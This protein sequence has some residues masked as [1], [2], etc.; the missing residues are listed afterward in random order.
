MDP[1]IEPTPNISRP[2]AVTRAVQLLSASFV[3][4]AIRAVY[5]LVHKF[6]GTTLV[7]SIVFLIIFFGICFF[8]V[9]KIAAGRNWARIVFLVL[10]I[11]GLPLA[12]PTY[13]AELRTNLPYG[14]VSIVVAI[15]QVLALVLLF[16]KTSNP[17]FRKHK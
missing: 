12:T 7:L 4:G 2:V 15:I 8:F 13:I 17:W 9:S 1:V 3:I 6:S 14:L 5:N 16:A 10:L 11:I